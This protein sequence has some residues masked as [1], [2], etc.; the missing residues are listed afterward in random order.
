M[1]TPCA[2]ASNGANVTSRRTRGFTLVELMTVVGI[3]AIL[4][5]IAAPSFR[6]LIA[7]Q[8]IRSAA[9]AITESLWLA[10]AEATKRNADVGFVFVNAAT[11]WNVPDPSGGATPLLAQ[12]GFPVVS[13][14]A[15]NGG[16][17]QFNFNAYGRL[18]TGSGW[19]QFSDA[20]A[21]IYRCVTV[22]TTGR[23]TTT[24]GTCQ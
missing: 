14:V 8:R 24:N 7:K 22:S 13:S 18:S 4:A 11:G 15:Q 10:R 1:T 3:V 21:G 19:I 17:V 2:L 9:S 6:Q 23:A 20:Q 12:Q 5:A 16:S